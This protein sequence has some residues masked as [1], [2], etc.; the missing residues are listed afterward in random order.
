MCPA[1]NNA[2]DRIARATRDAQ[3]GR[4]AQAEAAFREI[5]A[6]DPSN[7]AAKFGLATVLASGAK[8]NE[9]IGLFREVVRARPDH[10]T[11]WVNFGNALLQHGN[12]GEAENAFRAALKV[13]PESFSALYGLGCALQREGR[14]AEAE[15]YFRR[16][17]RC[18]PNDPGLLMNLG[19]ALKQQRRFAE[20]IES[21]RKV[22]QVKP[23]LHQGWSALGQTLLELGSPQE[24]EQAFRHAIQLA[25]ELAEARVGLG[26]A[27]SRRQHNDSALESYLSAITVDPKSQ[28]AH[29]KAEALLLKTAG[30]AG[31]KS[32]F[33]RLLENHVYERPA[34]AV[35]DALALV[36]AYAYPEAAVLE[37]TR[38]L[39]RQF[40]PERLYSGAWWREQLS[41]L[42]ASAAGHDKVFRGVSSAVYSW[43][44]PCLE[45]LQAVAA[46]TGDTVL[47]S[48][49]A[50]TG[51]WE[52]LLAR[53]FGA[54]V[55]AGDRILR[56][57]FIDMIAE[58]YGAAAVGD[59]EVVFLAWIP[60]GVDAVMNLLRQVR[61]GQKLVVVGQGPDDTGKARI[62][63]TEDAFRYLETVFEPAGRVPLGYYS[64]IRDDVG[65]YQRR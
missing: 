59:G 61:P 5:L 35:Q 43:S 19:T 54:R 7:V 1:G 27:L 17:L 53:H 48:F 60:Q 29:T 24:A 52:W 30:A 26:D 21:Y 56:R 14:S 3:C 41:R 31:E 28:N 37:E 63:A 38:A 12:H 20:A 46:F 39:L 58:D 50:G 18:Q 40:D 6:S 44:P 57:R 55:L 45:A 9:A 25:P 8:L 15:G 2:E 33:A 49:G 36:D 4:Y 32:L 11:A 47:H 42:G 34:D 65:M 64:Y 10:L 62:C 51:Y 16:A 22:T 13:Q 23:G